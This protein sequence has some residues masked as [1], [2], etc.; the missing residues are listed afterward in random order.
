MSYGAE[1]SWIE[2]LDEAPESVGIDLGRMRRYR[3]QRIRDEM[4]RHDIGAV[5]LSDAVNI[6]YATGSRNMQ[7]F[8]SRNAPSRYLLLTAERSILYEFTGAAHL[9]DGLDT[10]D[11]VRPA[12][13]AS[14][15]A[16]GPAIAVREREWANEMAATIRGLLGRGEHRVG[17]ERLN[18]GSALGLAATGFR[19]VDAQM[20]VEMARAIKSYDEIACIRAS[21]RM[22]EE[23]VRAVRDALR[24][25]LTEN[26]LWAILHA[27]V[28]ASNGDYVETRLLSS[29]PRTNPW[30]QE[31]S[32]R[33]IRPNELVAL[34]TDVVGC[35]GYYSDFSRTFHA[36][37]DA[38]TAEQRSLYRLAL[39]QVEHNISIIEPGLGFREYAD[40]AWNIPERFRRNRYYLS[41]HGC[42]M[43]GE[44]PYLYHRADFDEAGYDGTIE[45]GMTL[46][47]E[48]YIGPDDGTE[49]VKL[50][51]QILVTARGVELLSRFPL[52]EALLA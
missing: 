42:G 37:P 23:A 51:E 39:E 7:V 15:V 46:C 12:V 4:A 34:D 1:R 18:A 21:L 25:G 5:V 6:R 47:V 41:A 9:A 52:D 3:L 28:I 44:Y 11:D 17:L 45:P 38:P 13:T 22:T 29:G 31:S 8:T 36:G 33:P 16:T 14:F 30:F 32:S 27:T 2:L 10:I 50:E 48:S 24:P 43:T 40:R 19:I 26:E 49:G 35:H 20:P